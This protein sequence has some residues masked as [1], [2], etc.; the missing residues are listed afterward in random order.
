MR[1]SSPGLLTEADLKTP[2]QHSRRRLSSCSRA[3]QRDGVCLQHELEERSERS[4]KTDAPCAH[5][6]KR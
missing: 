6:D 4:W 2:R 1:Q 5:E 3:P